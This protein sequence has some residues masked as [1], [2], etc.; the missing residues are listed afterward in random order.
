MSTFFFPQWQM[1]SS[2]ELNKIGKEWGTENYGRL[3]VEQALK[4]LFQGSKH[5]GDT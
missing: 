1:C 2:T 3:D 5:H 4:W